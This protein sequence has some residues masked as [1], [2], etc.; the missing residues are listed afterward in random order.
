MI[1]AFLLILLLLPV[2]LARAKEHRSVMIVPFILF[3]ICWIPAAG[4]ML[5]SWYPTSLGMAWPFL[6]AGFA[7]WS[8]LVFCV[9]TMVG[10]IFRKRKLAKQVVKPE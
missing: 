6:V 1:I 4:L 8:P 2:Y 7:I 10:L 5:F 9:G 3:L